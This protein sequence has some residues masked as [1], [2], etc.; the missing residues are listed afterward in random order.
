MVRRTV[1]ALAIG[2]ALGLAAAFAAGRVLADQ[3]YGVSVAD[4]A[5]YAAVVAVLAAVALVASLL[6]AR[7]AARVDP[8]ATLSKL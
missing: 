3:V 7:R 8:A 6:P 1:P 4:P 5:S 2:L